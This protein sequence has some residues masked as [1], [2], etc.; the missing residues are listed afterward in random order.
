MKIPALLLGLV[1]FCSPVLAQD[2]SQDKMKA[3]EAD[4][5]KK[6]L[7]GEQHKAFM[8]NCV[9]AKAEAKA[10]KKAKTPQQE[11]MTKCNAGAKAKKLKGDPRKKFMS[12]CLK[13]KA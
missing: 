3:C 2:A 6:E 10:E 7:K 8:K 11:K 4:A 13:K 5:A 9:G 1:L 12:D